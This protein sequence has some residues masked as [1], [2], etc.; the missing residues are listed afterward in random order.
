MQ[1]RVE[2]IDGTR[3]SDQRLRSVGRRNARISERGGSRFESIQIADAVLVGNRHHQNLPPL[4]AATDREHSHARRRSG[5]SPA[6]CLRFRSVN[7]LTRRTRNAP[8]KRGRRRN[9]LRLRKVRNPRREKTRIPSSFR[10]SFRRTRLRNIW[11]S[12]VG[13]E[14]RR[15]HSTEERRNP[16]KPSNH[17][18]LHSP[19]LFSL[20][21]SGVYHEPLELIGSVNTSAFVGTNPE[22]SELISLTCRAHASRW[23]A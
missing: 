10:D 11:R 12:S 7:K 1:T 22:Q 4:F 17:P 6:V 2:V 23:T 20:R 18:R 14:R 19:C 3:R 16:R 13:R 21:A 15:P 5:Q 9:S 8:K